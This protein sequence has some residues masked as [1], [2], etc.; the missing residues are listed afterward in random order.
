MKYAVALDIGGTK[1]EGALF[2]SRMAMLRKK[3]VYYKKKKTESDVQI[4]RK[5]FL[6]TVDSLIEELGKGKKL[7]GIGVSIPDV[8]D[9]AG[10]IVGT[11]K[12]GSI[13]NFRL[14]AYL[15][16][17]HRCRVVVRNDADCFAYAEAMLGAGKGYDNVIGVI[18]GT[19]M[20]AGIVINRQMY[21]GTTGSCGEFGHNTVNAS[22][23]EDRLGWKGTVEAYA[24][25]PNL[26]KHYIESGGKIA[27]PDPQKIYR[28]NEPAA[29]RSVE[30]MLE[31]LAIGLASLMNMLDPGIIV[32]GGGLSNLPAYKR[33]NA[34]AKKHTIDG[35]R[36]YL[37]IVKNKLGDS[38]GIYGAGLLAFGK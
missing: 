18:W 36:P 29:K 22:G 17:K 25:G 33:L 3:R 14:G 19:G 32:M 1:V 21:T 35:L 9:K 27:D 31:H 30:D 11:N 4:S 37:K 28:S 6:Q 23:P 10:S 34:I 2:N 38:G 8:V 12:I 13:S 16:R 5:R 26:V 24:A 15:R 7:E 20:G